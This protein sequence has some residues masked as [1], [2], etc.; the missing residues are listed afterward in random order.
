MDMGVDNFFDFV[1]YDMFQ[2]FI[3]EIFCIIGGGVSV[4]LMCIL[5]SRVYFQ[6]MFW[7]GFR[8]IFVCL[9]I[10]KEDFLVL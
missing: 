4:V 8:G 7:L 5:S 2:K 3:D 9:G 6:V 10:F 1:V